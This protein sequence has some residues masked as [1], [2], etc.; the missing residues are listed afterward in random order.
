MSKLQ[1]T[2]NRLGISHVAS[3]SGISEYRYDA[4][5]L[6]IL[7]VPNHS[8]PVVTTMVLY[9]V[10]S[11][12]E[13][14]GFTGSTHFLEHMMFKGTIERNS[15]NGNGIDDLLKPIGAF[16]NATTWFD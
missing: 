5:G 15:G 9:R 7:L 6:K 14:A 1:E 12:N 13:G 16:Y 2:L 10:G 4:N 8:A 11:R 3:A